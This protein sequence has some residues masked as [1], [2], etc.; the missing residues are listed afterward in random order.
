[1]PCSILS[2]KTGG[3]SSSP[4]TTCLDRTSSKAWLRFHDVETVLELTDGGG[5]TGLTAGEC[6]LRDR[7]RIPLSGELADFPGLELGRL[8]RGRFL[9]AFWYWPLTRRLMSSLSR[10][11]NAGPP[12]LMMRK[13]PAPSE[14]RCQHLRPGGAALEKQ[15]G[16][17]GEAGAVPDLTMRQAGCWNRA[18]YPFQVSLDAPTFQIHRY[19]QSTPAARLPTDTEPFAAVPSSGLSRRR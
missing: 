7:L 8:G 17:P 15:G 5:H 16:A 14:S 18:Q 11:M 19:R 1:M 12:W 3:W 4:A 13:A 2:N 9:A 6:S 10:D